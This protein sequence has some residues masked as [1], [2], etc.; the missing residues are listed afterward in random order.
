MSLLPDV[1]PI[2]RDD[3]DVASITGLRIYRHGS[4]PQSVSAPYVT[5]FVVT[6]N[7][8]NSLGELPRVDR[9]EVQVDCWS[10]NTGSGSRGIETLATAVRDA[11]EPFAHMT[12][13]LID[14][15]D[16]ETQRYRIGMQFTFWHHR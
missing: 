4:A 3:S 6:G 7:P 5:W 16:V 11:L 10:D 14:E 9:H 12:A 8:E 1:F 13:I 2:L 15:R